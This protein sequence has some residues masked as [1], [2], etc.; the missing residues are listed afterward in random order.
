MPEV[1]DQEH[2]QR[3]FSLLSKLLFPEKCG[4]YKNQLAFQIVG[5]APPLIPKKAILV[6]KNG[7][8]L[9]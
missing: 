9:T 4:C 8:A 7:K 3:N 1:L 2:H 6:V 5:S